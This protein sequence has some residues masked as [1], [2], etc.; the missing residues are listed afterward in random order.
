[1]P[2]LSSDWTWSAGKAAVKARTL[3]VD[4]DG[5]E[6]HRC[7]ARIAAHCTGYHQ[8]T[9]HRTPRRCGD[10]SPTNL[11]GVCRPCHEYIHGHPDWSYRHGF[12]R[13][14]HQVADPEVL[15]IIG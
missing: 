15:D 13:R 8:H 7:E 9:H 1:M 6:W 5:Y 10:H 12:M 3:Q 4:A 2:D 11:L 14:W